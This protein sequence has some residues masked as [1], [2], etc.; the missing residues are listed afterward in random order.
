M[1]IDPHVQRVAKIGI[2]QKLVHRRQVVRHPEIVVSEIGDNPAAGAAQC[3]VTMPLALA[4]P[5]GKIE[6]GGFGYPEP[7]APP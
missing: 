5:L 7:P 1:S 3:L 2:A 6:K 4:R